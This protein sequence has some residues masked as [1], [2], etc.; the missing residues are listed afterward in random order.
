M[1]ITLT[2]FSCVLFSLGL[3]HFAAHYYNKALD[4]PLHD[5][6]KNQTKV[7]V[8]MFELFQFFLDA[9]DDNNL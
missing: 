1:I 9:M 7:E 4:F 6:S 3:I 8:Y 2:S 5:E